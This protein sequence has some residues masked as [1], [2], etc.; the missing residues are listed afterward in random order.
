[1]KRVLSVSEAGA[2]FDCEAFRICCA[3]DCGSEPIFEVQ[4]EDPRELHE[5]C[6]KHLP[7]V[8]AAVLVDQGATSKQLREAAEPFWTVE[9]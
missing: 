5:V 7:I 2:L 8:C 9:S 1:M 6:A 4:G 3:S